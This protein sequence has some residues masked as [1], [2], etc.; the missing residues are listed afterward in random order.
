M[1]LLNL[2]LLLR[3]KLHDYQSLR[4]SE[5]YNW[6]FFYYCTITKTGTELNRTRVGSGIE[7][8]F[9][10]FFQRKPIQISK[11]LLI[12]SDKTI[13]VFRAIFFSFPHTENNSK[14]IL[15][16]WITHWQT[17][18]ITQ[19]LRLVTIYFRKDRS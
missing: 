1:D 18:C 11:A 17:C 3:I 7:L 10:Q 14:S 9:C 13:F 2:R 15:S 5:Y 4:V 8:I 6:F 16:T 19:L 12:Y